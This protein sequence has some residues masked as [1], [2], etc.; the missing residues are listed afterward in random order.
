MDVYL[1]AHVTGAL[2]VVVWVHGGGFVDGTKKALRNY[3]PLLVARGYAAVA[4]EYCKAPEVQYPGQTR[5][6]LAALHFLDTHAGRWHLDMQ[7]V[8]LGG[9]SAGTQIA[10]Q[11]IMVIRE[12][13]YALAVGL[14]PTLRPGQLRGA[15]LFS[16]TY[17][18]ILP[19]HS[20]HVG[21]LVAYFARCMRWAYLGVK[22][23]SPDGLFR[24]TTLERWVNSRFPPTLIV[25]GDGDPLLPQSRR[26]AK[27]LEQAGV[28]T[29][30]L[31][32]TNPAASV[33]HEFQ[34]DPKRPDAHK[35]LADTLAWLARW[36]PATH[37]TH[38]HIIATGASD[39]HDRQG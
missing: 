5:E 13:D 14:Q 27:A 3:L 22:H 35:V 7:R 20:N 8:V 15:M 31:L 28:P 18:F 17:N 26:M 37:A 24:Y 36:V 16:G 10:A 23:P 38:S 9:D 29:R 2:P 25:D 33:P 21:W 6:V 34:F 4:V 19:G 39:D 30:W 32:F 11:S 12:P 1:P